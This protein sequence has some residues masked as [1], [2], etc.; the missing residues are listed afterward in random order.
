MEGFHDKTFVNDD[1]DATYNDLEKYIFNRED[2][3]VSYTANDSAPVEAI[4]NEHKMED[5]A[6]PTA[7]V[8]PTVSGVL[9]FATE[10]M[11]I[12]AAEE[13]QITGGMGEMVKDEPLK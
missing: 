13:D 9:A 6:V 5:S 1:L 11:G 7:K 3:P 2:E 4:H 8:A 10:T 12:A